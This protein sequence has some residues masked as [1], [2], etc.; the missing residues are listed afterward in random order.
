MGLWDEIC[1]ALRRT[2]E[3][4]ALLEGF[5]MHPG[6]SRP[7]VCKRQL[8]TRG[9]NNASAWWNDR[10][11]RLSLAARGYRARLSWPDYGSGGI[12]LTVM[13]GS[14]ALSIENM[15]VEW[16]RHGGRLLYVPSDLSSALEDRAW[17][18]CVM[19]DE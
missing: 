12:N 7:L 6:I 13:A 8:P 14:G 18:W 3:E 1:W 9:I 2:T 11:V 4:F 17:Q 10:R 5:Y 16:L 15:Q 19:E